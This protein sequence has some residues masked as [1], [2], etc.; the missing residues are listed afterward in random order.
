M[1]YSSPGYTGM[2][3]DDDTYVTE[4]EVEVALDQ[5]LTELE[6]QLWLVEYM[7]KVTFD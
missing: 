7:R 4:H 1:A 3:Y 2:S 6:E 5:Y